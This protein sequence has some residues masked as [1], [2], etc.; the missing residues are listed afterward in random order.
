MPDVSNMIHNNKICKRLNNILC[1][2]SINCSIKGFWLLFH[3]AGFTGLKFQF[4]SFSLDHGY[5]CEISWIN[6]CRM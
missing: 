6:P 1:E 2:G 3:M 5:N 4:L